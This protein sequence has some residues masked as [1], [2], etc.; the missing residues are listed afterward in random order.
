MTLS[1]PSPLSAAPALT[2]EATLNAALDCLLE[3]LTIPTQGD[4]N[5]QTIFQVLIRAASK[6]DSIEHTTQQLT[7]VP[8]GNTMRYHLDKLDEM[9][10]LEAQLNQALQSR[11]PPRI[12]RGKQRLAIDLHLIPYYGNPTPAEQP[13]IYRS[14]AK[15]GTTSFFAYATVYVIARN[16]RVT[17]A[18]HAV[19]RQETLVATLTYL[20][21]ALSPLRLGIKRLYLD[22]GFFCV[23]VIR[24][25]KALNLPFIMPAII[26]GKKGGTRQL[27]KGRKSYFTTYRLSGSYGA[28]E[29]NMGVVCRYQRGQRGRRGIQY[30]VYAVH[31]IKLALSTLHHNYRSRFGIETSYRSKNLC[32]IRTTTKNPVVRLL[33]VALAFVLVNLWV[34]LRW[35]FVSRSRFGPRLVYQHLFP[36]KTMLEFLCHAVEH[37]FPVVRAVFLPLTK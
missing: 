30:L 7:G 27:L 26:R 19:H 8:T 24:W 15:L 37:H 3:H 25:L 13:Y 22:R 6:Q 32:R 31:G 12:A 5:P 33:F 9:Q 10:G 36:L 1:S 34:Y 17:L 28:V 20:L 4:C 29:C 11:V 21:A 14:Q 35:H 23:P 2:D 16:K 18:V